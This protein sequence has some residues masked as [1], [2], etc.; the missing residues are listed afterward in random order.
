MCLTCEVLSLD[1]RLQWRASRYNQVSTATH[2]LVG[3]IHY[4]DNTLR[5]N[6]ACTWRKQAWAPYCREG[7]PIAHTPDTV[8]ETRPDDRDMLELRP[9]R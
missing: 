5:A 4:S 8:N 1:P 3:K 6:S 7:S 2:H 9:G